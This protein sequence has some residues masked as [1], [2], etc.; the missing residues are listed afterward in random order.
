MCLYHEAFQVFF[1]NTVACLLNNFT[2]VPIFKTFHLLYFFIIVSNLLRWLIKGEKP[3]R[4]ERHETYDSPV[5]YCIGTKK[6]LLDTV[7]NR[8]TNPK[9]NGMISGVTD[10]TALSSMVTAFTCMHDVLMMH[11][12]S[13]PPLIF[14]DCLAI[15]ILQLITVFFSIF[16]V[17]DASIPPLAYNVLLP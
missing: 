6:S 9:S 5:Y 7:D 13:L 15:N 12:K 16:S 10:L 4:M 1:Q 11:H 8:C 14:Q 17:E 3:S 2:R